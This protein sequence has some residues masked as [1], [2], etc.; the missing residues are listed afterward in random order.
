MKKELLEEL[1]EKSNLL[2]EKLKIG[3]KY[4]IRKFLGEYYGLIPT[5][6][7]VAVAGVTGLVAYSIGLAHGI[8]DGQSISSLYTYASS[9]SRKFVL[10][11]FLV[12]QFLTY[13]LKKA[14]F[15]IFKGGE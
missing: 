6:G 13:K 7:G 15:S 12:G 2:D 10:P 14:I 4:K 5:L 1:F 3:K 9:I 11:G 8:Y